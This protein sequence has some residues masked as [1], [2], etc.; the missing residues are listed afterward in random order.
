MEGDEKNCSFPELSTE[1]DSGK[2]RYSN[3]I[4]IALKF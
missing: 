4:L 3:Y 1:G 2:S